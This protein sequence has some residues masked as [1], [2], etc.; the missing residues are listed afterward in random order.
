MDW[1]SKTLYPNRQL[2]LT[3]IQRRK[4]RFCEIRPKIFC[5]SHLKIFSAEIKKNSYNLSADTWKIKRYKQSFSFT[6]LKK[7]SK[8]KK[9]HFK[10]LWNSLDNRPGYE[11]NLISRT[12]WKKKIN[13]CIG[14]WVFIDRINA[15]PILRKIWN[16]PNSFYSNIFQYQALTCTCAPYTLQ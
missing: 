5:Y 9:I 1:I 15:G 16:Y 4:D 2:Y 8:R 10:I 7:I 6:Y 11:N 12:P 14:N 13:S 3:K